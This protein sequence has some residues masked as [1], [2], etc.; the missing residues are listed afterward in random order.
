MLRLSVKAAF[1]SRDQNQIICVFSLTF[2]CGTWFKVEG[3]QIDGQRGLLTQSRDHCLPQPGG[4]CRRRGHRGWGHTGCSRVL[5]D[6][7]GDL[8]QTNFKGERVNDRDPTRPG[9]KE[10][11][12]KV[13]T[14]VKFKVKVSAVVVPAAAADQYVSQQQ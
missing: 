9:R 1:V 7:R 8:G 2:V 12:V 13:R 14:K 10:S 4:G 5:L 11:R 3:Q 6:L